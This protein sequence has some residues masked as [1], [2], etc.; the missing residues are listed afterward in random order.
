MLI[1]AQAIANFYITTLT[2]VDRRCR[3]PEPSPGKSIG[4]EFSWST[5]SVGSIMKVLKH[6]VKA[7]KLK[8]DVC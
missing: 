8:K 6:A 5:K 7:T 4:S 3:I 1:V 2:K